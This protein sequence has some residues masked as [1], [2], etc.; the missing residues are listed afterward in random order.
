MR[1]KLAIPT[2]LDLRIR[3]APSPIWNYEKMYIS[4]LRKKC[5]WINKISAKSMYIMNSNQY[6]I[7]LPKYLLVFEV[8][9]Y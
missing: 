3:G 2:S 4:T 6:A 1:I 9:F 8:Y 7:E 5:Y